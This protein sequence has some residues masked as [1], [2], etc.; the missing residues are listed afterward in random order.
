MIQSFPPPS[1]SLFLE[2][3]PTSPRNFNYLPALGTSVVTLSMQSL[4]GHE[5]APAGTVYHKW[6]LASTLVAL[7]PAMLPASRSTYSVSP[8]LLGLLAVCHCP[9]TLQRLKTSQQFP[10]ST[11]ACTRFYKGGRSPSARTRSALAGQVLLAGC[12]QA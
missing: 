7:V 9:Q 11:L 1:A 10:H 3:E 8:D 5:H 6:Y 2:N 12:G 4:V